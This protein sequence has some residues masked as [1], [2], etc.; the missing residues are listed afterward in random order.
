[1]EKQIQRIPHLEFFCTERDVHTEKILTSLVRR[2]LP[3]IV[4]FG[5]IFLISLRFGDSEE[6][7]KIPGLVE[8]LNV[9]RENIE[10]P[11]ILFGTWS[12]EELKKEGK[13]LFEEFIYRVNTAYLFEPIYSDSVKDVFEKLFVKMF[14]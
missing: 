6:F 5:K 12:R 13:G 2:N 4:N 3:D 7:S 8:A 14:D 11:V 9:A 10:C 1:M